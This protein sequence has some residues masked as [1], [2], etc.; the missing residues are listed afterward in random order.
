MKLWKRVD[1]ISKTGVFLVNTWE[2][3]RDCDAD[4]AAT[5]LAIFQKDE[6]KEV[7]V[8]SEEKP[9]NSIKRLG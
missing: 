6:P 5:W 2:H 3:V 4:T 1:G 9:K 7:F 8:L